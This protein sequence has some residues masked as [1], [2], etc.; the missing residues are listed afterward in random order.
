VHKYFSFS[1]SS[2]FIWSK[3]DQI[4][5]NN[6]KVETL[7]LEILIVFLCAHSAK[8]GWSDLSLICELAHLLKRHPQIDWEIIE[9]YMGNLGGRTMVLLSLS[10]TQT[11]YGTNLPKNICQQIIKS[12]P[13]LTKLS[14]Q[15]EEQIFSPRNKLLDIFSPNFLYSQSMESWQ[16]RFL[17]WLNVS[18]TPTSIEMEA[19]SLPTI[20]FPLYY[21]IRI[22]RLSYKHLKKFFI[23]N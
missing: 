14:A 7:S 21:P 11:I 6:H 4:N 12:E 5:L 18:T 16:D 15:V 1:P 22:F 19:I 9:S 3:L 17:Y 2:K 23:K 13:I 10:L 20:L 8:H